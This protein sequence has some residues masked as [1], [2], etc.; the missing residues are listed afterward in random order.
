[1]IL[2]KLRRSE[3]LGLAGSRLLDQDTFYPCFLKDLRRCH[4]EVIIECPFVTMR[5]V[6]YLLPALRGL[7]KRR[8]CVVVNTKPPYEHSGVLRR[9]AELAIVAMQEAGA[10]VLFTGGHHRKLVILDMETVYEGSL[11][12]LSQSDSCEIMRRIESKE[13]AMQ[14]IDFLKLERFCT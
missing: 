14:L 6:H 10:R 5:R 7:T 8:V 2:A 4:K 13:A 11:N 9:Q 12:I 1:M 3:Q